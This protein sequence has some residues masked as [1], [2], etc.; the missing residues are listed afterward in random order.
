LELQ[1]EL[2][3]ELEQELSRRVHVRVQG[4]VQGDK[5]AQGEF[6]IQEDRREV[7]EARL[8]VSAT[9]AGRLEVR[10]APKD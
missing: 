3:K 10:P 7:V 6:E 1:H 8:R 5:R 9:E 2:V 4:E